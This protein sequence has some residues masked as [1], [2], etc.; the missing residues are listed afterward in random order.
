M[1]TNYATDYLTDAC[2]S[3]TRPSVFLTSK[4]DGSIDIWDYLLRQNEPALTVQIS[5]SAIHSVRAQ[6]HGKLVSAAQQDG[7]VTIFEL[8]DGL[9][10]IQPEEKKIFSEV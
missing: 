3:P 1:S 5:N 8:C 6:E 4:R 7:S 9:S 10:K 2:W